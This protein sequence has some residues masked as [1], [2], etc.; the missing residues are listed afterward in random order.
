MIRRAAVLTICCV[1]LH[2]AA[3]HGQC[4]PGGL[5][6]PATG[7]DYYRFTTNDSNHTQDVASAVSMWQN[8]GGCFQTGST[9]QIPYPT[10]AGVTNAPFSTFTVN[11]SSGQ[12]PNDNTTCGGFNGTTHTIT[13]YASATISGV[14]IV[15]STNGWAQ[16]VAHEIGHAYG[17]D[18][19]NGT[20]G[21]CTDIMQTLDGYSHSVSTADC[22]EAKTQRPSLDKDYP[23]D[24]S[25]QQVCVGY[26]YG[27][28]CP[29]YNGG[30]PIV[31]SLDGNT[32]ALDG[33]DDPVLFDLYNSGVPV[34]TSW[35]ARNSTTGFVAL[36]L[37]SNGV[38]DNGG[39]L[40]GNHTRLPDATFADN[41]FIALAVYDR[42]EYGGND[43]GRIDASDEIFSRLHIWIDKNH[44]GI[45]ESNELMML[46]EA[47]VT[48]VSLSYRLDERTDQYGNRLRYR[49]RA[50][51]MRN[52]RV[53]TPLV[54][55][56]VFFVPAL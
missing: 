47:G 4:Q 7:P 15:C 10:T 9:P 26:C 28:S 11:F 12:N 42:V 52:A 33:P 30:S 5:G 27:G 21:S 2:S 54:I 55:Y 20:P 40:F 1:L 18:D 56:D 49:G 22:N 35:T 32:P 48:S 13:M 39:E 41:G 6:S 37:D 3:A 45:S 43:D 8:S 46:R 23:S 16:A 44:N 19:V 51:L 14:T 24:P 17:L 25:C 34:R 50:T 31:I 29:A 38:I 53:A 36:D